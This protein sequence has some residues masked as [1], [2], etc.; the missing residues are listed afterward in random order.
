MGQLCVARTAYMEISSM[1]LR[2]VA[3]E[4]IPAPSQTTT[5]TSYTDETT[6]IWVLRRDMGNGRSWESTLGEVLMDWCLRRLF[7]QHVILFFS[8]E[9]TF[10]LLVLFLRLLLLRGK[11]R[12]Y[13]G[14][15]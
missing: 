7:P 15:S 6:A 5:Q 12:D 4:L 3:L 10:I 1:I 8:S 13:V 14:R 11:S 9:E 2:Q